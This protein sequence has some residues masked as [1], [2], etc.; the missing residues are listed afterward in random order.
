MESV[1]TDEKDLDN[2]HGSIFLY[3]VYDS[4]DIYG[5]WGRRT[6]DSNAFCQREQRGIG[7]KSAD[8]L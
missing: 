1:E 8:V 7:D 6:G 3:T 5:S 4:R 2:M